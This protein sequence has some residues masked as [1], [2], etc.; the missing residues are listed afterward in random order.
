M[1]CVRDV[2][3][4]LTKW[5]NKEKEFISNPNYALSTSNDN[6][7][8]HPTIAIIKK[9]QNKLKNVLKKC[10]ENEV[11]HSAEAKEKQEALDVECQARIGSL[12]QAEE[13]VRSLELQTQK[14]QTISQST[15][16]STRKICIQSK[17]ISK[18]RSKYV[19]RLTIQ[20]SSA[21]NL[22]ERTK[23]QSANAAAAAAAI[24][25][26]KE[27]AKEQEEKLEGPSSSATGGDD[28][29]ESAT[30][31]TGMQEES[32]A[33]ADTY[34]GC[35]LD[36]MAYERHVRNGDINKK[37]NNGMTNNVKRNN[38]WGLV[39]AWALSFCRAEAESAK[40]RA[41]ITGKEF[42]IDINTACGKYS[43]R[44]SEQM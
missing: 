28:N 43:K 37:K 29:T 14:I 13:R 20:C 12:K 16:E 22:A 39:S 21:E 3:V 11:L 7:D 6:N 19:N 38:V 4:Q 34:G 40:S 41:L 1:K 10:E 26:A 24:E 23:K 31:A 44:R 30:G 32:S 9:N 17:N 15:Y 35:A 27:I 5:N 8:E 33:A 25:V 36:V 18:K 2:N 42:H